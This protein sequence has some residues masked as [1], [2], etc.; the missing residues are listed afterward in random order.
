MVEVIEGGEEGMLL[1]LRLLEVLLLE[2]L[3]IDP[4][5]DLYLSELY[6]RLPLR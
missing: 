1:N 5:L 2:R 4:P 3:L 6:S